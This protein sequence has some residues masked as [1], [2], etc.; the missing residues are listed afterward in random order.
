MGF[1]RRLSI[2]PSEKF[3]AA[4]PRGSCN[5]FPQSRMRKA[6]FELSL[7]SPA[8]RLHVRQIL[9]ASHGD[10]I[11][12]QVGEPKKKHWNA[13]VRARLSRLPG[14]HPRDS[15]DGSHDVDLYRHAA[16]LQDFA[17]GQH[18]LGRYVVSLKSKPIQAG[19]TLVSFNKLQRSQ[20]SL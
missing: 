20:N 5:I 11:P 12:H 18:V 9:W 13:A 1:W 2:K 17:M 7:L 8:K 6:G 10:F 14:I 15:G 4:L 19:S 3:M 16:E